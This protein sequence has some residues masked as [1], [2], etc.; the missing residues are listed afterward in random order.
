MSAT[1]ADHDQ[2]RSRED[3]NSLLS[4]SRDAD[5]ESHRDSAIS[6]TKPIEETSSQY[7]PGVILL[8][9]FVLSL[10]IMALVFYNFP[11]LS[12]EDASQLKLPRSL[13]D[14]KDL[15]RLLSKYKDTHYYTV[16]GA[17]VITYVFLQT[18][19]IPGS[20]SL[21]I[22]SG[23]LFPFPVALLLVCTCSATGATF[24]YLLF[25]MVGHNIVSRYFPQRVNGW[26]TQ[27]AHHHDDMLWYIIFL[28]ITPFLPNWFINIASPI[29]GVNLTPFY[30]GTFLGVA[31]PSFFFIRAGTTL[32]ELTTATGH[33]SIKSILVLAGFAVL[34]LLPVFFKKAI[35]KKLE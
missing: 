28:R 9:I 17:V 5:A 22:L 12:D 11:E 7:G 24:C 33:V 18:F 27:V 15:G 35:R 8:V 26:K 23:F 3:S 31:P 14:A 10:A 16:L 20:I 13:D 29:V 25:S 21:S 2:R 34:S 32:Y 1:T 30:W 6:H 19:A 4:K